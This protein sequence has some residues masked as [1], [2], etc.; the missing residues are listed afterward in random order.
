MRAAY[1]VVKRML[2]RNGTFEGQPRIYNIDRD[3]YF[4]GYT[5][6]N[7]MA[8]TA[9]ARTKTHKAWFLGGSNVVSGDLIEDRVDLSRYLVM[10][11][12]AEYSGGLVAYLDGTL[13]LV[14]STC[15]VLRYDDSEVD[16]FG[17]TTKEWAEVHT[18]VP[19]MVNP[20]ALDTDSGEDKVRDTSKI[21]ISMQTK[22]MLQ[23]GDRLE[24]SNGFRYIVRSIDEESLANIYSLQVDKDSR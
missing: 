17:R 19:I 23:Q 18:D 1:S 6:I 15:T 14:T 13:Y 8:T 20:V 21:K 11:L 22:F 9:Y 12:K 5:E 2:K 7:T 16:A 10:S 24:T 3:E 4:L